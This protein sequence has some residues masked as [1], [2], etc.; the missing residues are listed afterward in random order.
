MQGERVVEGTYQHHHCLI[1][2]VTNHF[3]LLALCVALWSFCSKF[4]KLFRL[5]VPCPCKGVSGF[6]DD[7]PYLHKLPLDISMRNIP[8]I[9]VLVRTRH[10]FSSNCYEEQ[11]GIFNL[12]GIGFE[13]GFLEI[14]R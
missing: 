5:Y 13:F 14:E 7:S 8:S 4:L 6:V 1:E 2:V 3:G 10:P 11:E 9:W 12:L